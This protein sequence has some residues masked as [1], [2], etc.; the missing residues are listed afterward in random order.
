MTGFG[1]ERAL[2]RIGFRRDKACCGSTYQNA[3]MHQAR[4]LPTQE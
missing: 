1:G 2:A 4:T 3:T